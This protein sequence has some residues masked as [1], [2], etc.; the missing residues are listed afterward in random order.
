MLH[1]EVFCN[2][3]VLYRKWN[4]ELELTNGTESRRWLV[5]IPD[6]SFQQLNGVGKWFWSVQKPVMYWRRQ[7]PNRNVQDCRRSCSIFNHT[8]HTYCKLL[9]FIV[10]L[11]GV[12]F[13]GNWNLLIISRTLP[14]SVYFKTMYTCSSTEKIN[15]VWDVHQLSSYSSSAFCSIRQ[16]QFLVSLIVKHWNSYKILDYVTC[17]IMPLFKW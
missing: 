9:S 8:G 4:Q 15:V 6:H 3:L 5:H 7:F 14:V 12:L 11:H 2:A 13:F 17:V 16:F 1:N 10:C